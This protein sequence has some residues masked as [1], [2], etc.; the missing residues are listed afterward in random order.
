MTETQSIPAIAAAWLAFTRTQT[1]A[2]WAIEA[3]DDSVDSAQIM[4][5]WLLIQQLGEH[6]G[7]WRAR[8]HGDQQVN[9]A[10]Q[11]DG[12][13]R[14]LGH[15][16]EHVRPLCGGRLIRELMQE[17]ERV[18]HAGGDEV[19]GVVLPLDGLIDGGAV[20]GKQPAGGR[21][22][23]QAG[24]VQVTLASAGRRPGRRSTAR[25][26]GGGWCKWR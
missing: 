14:W 9:R 23:A 7:R 13:R 26:S 18:R 5:G 6:V 3:V 1:E 4:D 21:G 25:S 15:K 20:L 22:R 17:R 24:Q 19:L 8:G 16:A 10:G 11:V 12:R 2:L